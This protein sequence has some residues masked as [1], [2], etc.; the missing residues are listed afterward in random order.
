MVETA[1]VSHFPPVCAAGTILLAPLPATV[2]TGGCWAAVESRTAA[3][4]SIQCRAMGVRSADRGRAHAAGPFGRA[5]PVNEHLRC[6]QSPD[7][8]RSCSK[9]CS[10]KTRLGGRANS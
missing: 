4:P 3:L 7:K 10:A 6:S 8:S 2:P 1:A 9:R 5:G